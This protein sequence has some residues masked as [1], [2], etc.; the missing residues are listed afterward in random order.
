MS[1]LDYPVGMRM[2]EIYVN[3]ELMPPA[4]IRKW[5]E[6]MEIGKAHLLSHRYK[7]D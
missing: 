3:V 2:T 1:Y 5:G 7:W 4:N 6:S